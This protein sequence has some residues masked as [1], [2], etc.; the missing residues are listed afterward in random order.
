MAVPYRNTIFLY[1]FNIR[2]F[3]DLFRALCQKTLPHA[4]AADSPE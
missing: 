4:A 2:E 1:R 3:Q